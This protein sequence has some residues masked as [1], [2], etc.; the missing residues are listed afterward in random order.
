MLDKNKESCPEL[1]VLVQINDEKL[2]NL[3]MTGLISIEY[4][5]DQL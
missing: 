5:P 1:K 3:E 4:L 2:K